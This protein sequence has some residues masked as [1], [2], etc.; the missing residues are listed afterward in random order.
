MLS[1]RGAAAEMTAALLYEI[2]VVVDQMRCAWIRQLMHGA[3]GEL[4]LLW[5]EG[6]EFVSK[7][8]AR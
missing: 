6:V 7:F 3:F 2:C 4:C 8:N 5:S 1:L